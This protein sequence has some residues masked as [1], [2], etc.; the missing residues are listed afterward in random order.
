MT[1]IAEWLIRAFPAAAESDP[2]SDFIRFPIR[3]FH[4]YTTPH[5]D[6]AH[7]L[8]LGVVHQ[9]NRWLQIGLNGLSLFLPGY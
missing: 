6:R 5:P 8:S 9:T 3:R 1:T 7:F 2:V 4:R